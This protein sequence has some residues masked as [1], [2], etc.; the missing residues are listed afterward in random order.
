M[1]ERR[2]RRKRG[3]H[4]SGDQNW[5]ATSCAGDAQAGGV[6][7]ACLKSKHSDISSDA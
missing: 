3:F 4:E 5:Q 1:A 6:S 7:G 2:F